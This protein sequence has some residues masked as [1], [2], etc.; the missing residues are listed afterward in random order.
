[1]SS[2]TPNGRDM[3]APS[4]PTN[5]L[6]NTG[7]PSHLP[8]LPPSPPPLLLPSLKPLP[9]FLPFSEI[10]TQLSHLRRLSLQSNALATL[11]PA[12][13]RL[14]LL[15]KLF[16]CGN[17]VTE[18]PLEICAL[19]SLTELHSFTHDLIPPPARSPSCPSAA[20]NAKEEQ[21]HHEQRVILSDT[22]N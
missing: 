6:P 4:S 10:V 7:P 12:I 18:L 3:G 21:S 22:Q 20:L 15:E 16:I 11:P 5:K 8:L 13:S 17:P 9:P 2:A 14:P 19:S 1:M